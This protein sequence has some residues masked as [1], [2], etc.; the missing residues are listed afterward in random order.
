MVAILVVLICV[1][2]LG[3]LSL[4]LS[5]E[6]IDAK[7]EPPIVLIT[8]FSSLDTISSS[9]DGV[10]VLVNRGS[11]GILSSASEDS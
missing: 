6:A 4:A 3:V 9:L 11:G 10:V 5:S 2:S 1:L 8:S 7:F